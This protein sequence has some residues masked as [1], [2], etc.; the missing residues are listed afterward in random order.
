M[1]ACL[2]EARYDG[3][4]VQA[5]DRMCRLDHAGADSLLR[6]SLPSA[7]PAL[8]Y[9]RGLVLFNRFNDLGDTAALSQAA[10]LWQ[11][12]VTPAAPFPAADTQN[13]SAY[14]G[15]SELQLSYV[16]SITGHSVRAAL[17][18]RKA[19]SLLKPLRGLAEADAALALFEYY[20][21]AL[22]KGVDWLPFVHP[23]L[24]GPRDRLAAAVPR[25]R[26][27]RGVLQTSLLWLY[28]DDGRFDQGL[29]LIRTFLARYPENR[30]YQ[31][32]EADFRFRRK[33][34][35]SARD[36]HESLKEEYVRVKNASA[37]AACLPTGYLS[38]VGN[39]A[40]DYAAL[41]QGDLREKH[42]RIWSSPEF[43]EVL[44]W[45]PASLR[46]EVKALQ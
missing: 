17:C 44:P 14:A 33:E 4:I 1:P 11:S 20:Q 13:L 28:Y 18:G 34:F 21:A 27:L 32:M 7:A 19:E 3:A 16:A 39:L 40:K 38:A 36:L 45:L 41:H 6:A 8:A 46:R 24:D 37:C 9:F 25:S 22:L 35:A 12:V 5:L 2:F 15:L 43:T 30:L 26:Y 42:L 29:A 10:A 23:D 31:E